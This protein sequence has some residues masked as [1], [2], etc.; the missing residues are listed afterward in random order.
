MKSE[1]ACKNKG[2]NPAWPNLQNQHL[3]LVDSLYIYINYFR[4]VSTVAQV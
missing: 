4:G 3:N 1:M 2:K